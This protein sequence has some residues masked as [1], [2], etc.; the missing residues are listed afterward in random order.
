MFFENKSPKISLE[1][2]GSKSISNRLLILQAFF[3]QLQIDNLSNSEDTRVLQKALKSRKKIINIGHAGT[4]MRFLTAYYSFLEER[5]VLLTGSPRMKERPIGILVEALQQLGADISYAEKEGFPPLIIKGKKP[6]HNHAAL[7]THVSSQYVSALML[8]APAFEQGLEIKLKNKPT[9]FPYIQMTS[10][11]LERLGIGCTFKDDKIIISTG[12]SLPKQAV[13]VEPDWSAASYFFS[14]TALS[15]AAEIHLK[16][17]GKNSIQG[18]AVLPEH[19]AKLGVKTRFSPTGIILKKTRIPLPEY[20]EMDFS[21]T[22][23]LAQTLAVSCLGLRLKCKLSGLHTLKIKETDR[24]QA[25]KNE[26]SKFGAK[27]HL[28]ES[29]LEMK[30]PLQLKKNISVNTYNDHRM[31]MAF[32]PLAMKVP[33]EIKNPEVVVKSYPDFWKDFKKTGAESS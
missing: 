6:T 13:Y 18:D 30:P 22:P 23:D 10:S 33:I 26:L 27:V 15:D 24:L 21:D 1:L 3:P 20:I 2:T 11:L 17:F 14:V 31:A 16:G 12:F 28:T 19:Y 32:A 7:E 25:L 4:A 9:S 5:E 8:V 29:S